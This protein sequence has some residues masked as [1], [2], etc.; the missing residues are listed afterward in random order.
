[1]GFLNFFKKISRYNLPKKYAGIV[2]RDQYNFIINTSIQYH[3]EN[4]FVIV[5]INEG[6]I[7][8]EIDGEIKHRYLDQLLSIISA[9]KQINWKN[10]IYEYF[11]KLKYNPASIDYLYKNFNYASQFLRVLIKGESF[12]MQNDLNDC[13]SRIDFPKTN[14]FLVLEFDGQFHYVIRDER[15]EWKKENEELFEIAIRNIPKNEIA[16]KE[17]NLSENVKMIGFYSNDYSA[18]YLLNFK[19][20]PGYIKGTFGTLIAIPTKGT[21]LV[22]PIENKNIMVLI[23]IINP[24]VTK[25][26]NKNPGSITLHYYWLYHNE[27]HIFPIENIENNPDE[28]IIKLPNKLLDLLVEKN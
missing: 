15:L 24:D 17:H 9:E 14:T 3:K 27:F 4:R 18:S 8:V 5:R 7:V 11:N 28:K 1:M 13:I 19:R 23:T 26:Y 12:M 16:I 22:F 21:A 10:I 2:T 6:E 20:D 25:F